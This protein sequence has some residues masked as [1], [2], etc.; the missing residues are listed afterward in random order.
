MKRGRLGKFPDLSK[1]GLQEFPTEITHEYWRYRWKSFLDVL[2]GYEETRIEVEGL[3]Q[4]TDRNLIEGI[5]V[6]LNPFAA[7]AAI[8]LSIFKA[9]NFP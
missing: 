8:G 5:A 3:Q 9:L 4:T 7:A 1:M 6:I 2:E